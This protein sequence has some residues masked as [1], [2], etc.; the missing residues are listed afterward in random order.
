[1]HYFVFIGWCCD[2]VHWFPK[3]AE[4][5]HNFRRLETGKIILRD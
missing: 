2:V 3:G 4:G 5:I 1:M